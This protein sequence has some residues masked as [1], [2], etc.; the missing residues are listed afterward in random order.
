MGW[1]EKKKENG[2]RTEA[3]SE[4]VLSRQNRRQSSG[5]ISN[6]APRRKHTFAHGSR[7]SFLLFS[8]PEPSSGAGRRILGLQKF[9]NISDVVSTQAAR[10]ELRASHRE[11]ITNV[12][13]GR[14]VL[15]IFM[16]SRK[17][18]RVDAESW[19]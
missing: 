4:E 19:L 1:V 10:T 3:G 17:V 9:S 12:T 15:I 18:L 5:R 16:C 8:T 6:P 11:M 14:S 13:N 7:G 2:L